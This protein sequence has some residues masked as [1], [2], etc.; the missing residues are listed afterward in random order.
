MYVGPL[1]NKAIEYQRLYEALVFDAEDGEVPPD[2][3]YLLNSME[4]GLQRHF[5]GVAT[6]YRQLLANVEVCQQ[7]ADKLQARANKFKQDAEWMKGQLK[8]ALE[9]L[10][11]KKLKSPLAHMWI[12]T[13]GGKP[14][15]E[16]DEAQVPDYCKY[17]Y[18][19]MRID[20]AKIEAM[21]RDGVPMTFARRKPVG[22]HIRIK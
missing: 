9:T 5:E 13:N 2:A 18:T 8:L 10:G 20:K 15:I 21:L 14:G 16:I 3:S 7:E 17:E 4:G 6:V 19:E 11:V 12:Q 1:V 22:D